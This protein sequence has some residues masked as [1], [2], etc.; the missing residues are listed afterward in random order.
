VI[1]GY[2]VI[3]ADSHVLEP[4]DLWLRNIDPKYRDI[5]PQIILGQ[6]RDTLR[7]G[8]AA[9][10]GVKGDTVFEQ[11]VGHLGA[12]GAAWG[13]GELEIPYLRCRGG[14]EP[15][16]RIEHMNAEH[17]DKAMLFPGIGLVL[18][19]LDADFAAACYRA[20]NVWLAEFCSAYP[21][22]LYGAAMVPLQSVD[23][24]I[25]ELRFAREKLGLPAIFV[26]PNAY[27]GHMHHHEVFRP[28]W[29]EV[30]RLDVAV[31]IHSGSA[32][33]MPTTGLEQFGDWF[34]TRHI[35]THTMD[36]M[37]TMLSLVFCGVCERFPEIRFGFFEGGGGWV[38]GWLDRMDRHYQ[39][40]FYNGEL[41]DKPSNIF[42]R[43]CWIAFDP[44]EQALPHIADYIGH[45]RIL[46]SSDYPHPD[47]VP[48]GTKYITGNPALSDAAKRAILGDNARA[49][50]GLPR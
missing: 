10:H 48:D 18:G 32:G 4:P 6:D 9:T 39:K 40:V 25:A 1:D 31:S 37:Q 38:A 33:D 50:Y 11:G 24:A 35:V 17:I 49:F 22:R 14:Y 26:R 20:Y 42:K 7:I 47:G 19:G 46:F 44:A 43:Q 30:Q 15:K 8:G 36:V 16:A 28:F 41:T 2:T 23:H 21:D 27:Q 3:D 34:M 29:A 13:L 45:D 12:Y 5:A